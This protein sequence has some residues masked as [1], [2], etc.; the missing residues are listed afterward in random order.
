MAPHRLIVHAG[1]HKTGTTSVQRLLDRHRDTLD[2][3]MQVIL[4][5]DM[6]ALCDAARRYSV[7]RDP[8]DLGFVQ[9]EAAMLADTMTHDTVMLSSEDLS[10]HMPGRHG[11]KRYDAAPEIAVAMAETWAEALPGTDFCLA[12]TVRDAAP[13]LASCYVQHLRATR[14]TIT[15]DHYAREY[16]ASARLLEAV[17]AVQGAL[18]DV[19]VR[20]L[21]LEEIGGS[22]LGP[23]EALLHLADIPDETLRDLTPVPHANRAMPAEKQEAFLALN[24]STLSDADLRARKTAIG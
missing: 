9:Y 15:A 4:R 13:W 1:F 2:A 14:I 8:L 12:Y 3:H 16:A 23:A 7:S 18:P 20:A 22:R 10:G 24:R 19:D 5:A 17:A 6:R 11:L 21:A